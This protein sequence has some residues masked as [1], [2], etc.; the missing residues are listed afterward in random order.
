MRNNC[1]TISAGIIASANVIEFQV[2]SKLY[3]ND[4]FSFEPTFGL[5]L[6]GTMK[7]VNFVYTTV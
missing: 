1:I 3:A 4:D 2:N 5:V 7:K 6:V